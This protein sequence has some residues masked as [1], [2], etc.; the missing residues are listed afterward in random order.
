MK[1]EYDFSKGQRR[2]PILP[3]EGMTHVH[4]H[5]E[6]E[7]LEGLRLQAEKL[8]IGYQTLLN[9]ILRQHLESKSN[10]LSLSAASLNKEKKHSV[11]G[12]HHSTQSI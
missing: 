9:N 2:G 1:D 12:T 10:N 7:I 3:T 5:L 4:L 11:S 6:D 8:G